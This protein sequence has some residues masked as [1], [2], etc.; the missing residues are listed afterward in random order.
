VV[1]PG[2]DLAFV[3]ASEMLLRIHRAPRWVVRPWVAEGSITVV[4]G[5]ARESGKTAWLMALARSAV[6]GEAFLG[7]ACVVSAVVFL[8]EQGPASFS[9]ALREAGLV[10]PE[11]LRRLSVLHGGSARTLD[12]SHLVLGCVRRCEQTGARLLIFDSLDLFAG[13]GDPGGGVH[14]PALVT[15]LLEAAESGLGVVVVTRTPGGAL[16]EALRHLGRLASAS[17]VLVSL[18]RSSAGSHTMRQIDA[19]SRFAETPASLLVD[20]HMG[21][22]RIVAPHAELDPR[23]GEQMDVP[24]AG[25]VGFPVK[26]N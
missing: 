5:P 3:S 24:G 15:P 10:R 11:Q 17:D 8:T 23:S 1:R 14:D 12:W 7:E 25:L 9:M 21:V 13:S 22:Y 6:S 16:S 26:V 2:P 18:Q 20:R 19:M 4:T